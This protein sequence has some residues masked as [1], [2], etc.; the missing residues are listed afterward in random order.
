MSRIW[1]ITI[2]DLR[3]IA[4]D[5][6]G[7]FF[8]LFFP[9]IFA[10][11]FGSMYGGGEGRAI[12]MAVLDLDDTKVSRAYVDTLKADPAMGPPHWNTYFRVADIDAAKTAVE[13]AG[14]QV[15]QGPHEIPGGDFSMNCID[16]QGAAFGLVGGRPS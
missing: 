13:A 1:A 14:G 8:L 15:V 6:S 9:I 11:F 5:K 2:K 7:L 10:V 3:L 4:R 16:P 12:P